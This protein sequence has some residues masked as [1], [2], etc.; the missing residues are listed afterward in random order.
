MGL[1]RQP[2]A[3]WGSEEMFCRN[4]FHEGVDNVRPAID[5]QK[6]AEVKSTY[7]RASRSVLPETTHSL[8]RVLRPA[9]AERWWW[10]RHGWHLQFVLLPGRVA[11]SPSSRFFF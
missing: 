8:R 7:E 11:L 2:R 1:E 3:A 9:V 5:K 10:Q 6:P 4:F